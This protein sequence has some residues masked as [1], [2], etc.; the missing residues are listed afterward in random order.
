MGFG[1]NSAPRLRE[2]APRPEAES[3]N[4][5]VELLTLL[6]DS[7]IKALSAVEI[8]DLDAGVGRAGDDPVLGPD[9]LALLLLPPH[10]LVVV[11]LLLALE[12][13]KFKKLLSKYKWSRVARALNRAS[14]NLDHIYLDCRVQSI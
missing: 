2:L 5:G 9:D 12:K 14:R 11:D 6:S 8:P 4:L 3:H 13:C 7:H 1:K 10:P